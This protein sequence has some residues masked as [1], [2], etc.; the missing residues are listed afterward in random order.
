[1]I[2]KK[3]LHGGPHHVFH[4]ISALALIFFIGGG[5]GCKNASQQ[6]VDCQ[7]DVTDS[8]STQQALQDSLQAQEEAKKQHIAACMAFLT[9]FYQEA[10]GNFFDDYFIKERITK[11]AERELVKA[12]DYEC[13]TG[14]CLAT[15]LFYQE[16]G[17][18][19]GSI[20]DR[21]IE[22]VDENT[23]RVT[24]ISYCNAEDFQEYKYCVLLSVV[25]EGGSYKID[26][27]KMES[28]KCY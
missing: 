28:S 15:W 26:S 7:T 17:I 14:D 6:S 3:C 11:K 20:K 5:W 12:Y 27:I 23:Y 24:C 2:I 22:M 1:M 25:S 13:E 10:E 18:D 16:G 8:V 19:L 4:I 9:E 21:T